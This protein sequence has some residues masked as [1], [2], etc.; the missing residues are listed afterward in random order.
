[1][2]GIP[3]A[4]LSQESARNATIE[5]NLILLDSFAI[6]LSFPSWGAQATENAS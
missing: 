1:M 3:R 6:L 5:R 4:L 2:L